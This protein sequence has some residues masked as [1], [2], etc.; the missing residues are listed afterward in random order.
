MNDYKVKIQTY[1]LE[2]IL[3]K[4]DDIVDET[5]KENNV[6]WAKE[7]VSYQVLGERSELYYVDNVKKGFDDFDGLDDVTI[8]INILID[9]LEITF[10]TIG[11]G[12]TCYT[13]ALAGEDINE[14]P[15]YMCGDSG[16][17]DDK[18]KDVLN[19]FYVTNQLTKFLDA[20]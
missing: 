15:V 3:D 6:A 10:M 18:A 20:D 14:W 1:D 2:D 16:P 17:T 9:K 13:L 8:Y 4:L 11:R 12:N 5:L 19:S 7:F